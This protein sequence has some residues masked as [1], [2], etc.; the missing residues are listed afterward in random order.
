MT[1]SRELSGYRLDLVGVQEV[2]W[3][4]SGTAPAGKFTFFYGTG[5][6]SHELSTGLLYLIESY[7]KLRRLSLLMAGC[8]TY[9]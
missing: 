7:W 8:H 2:R 4:G 6:E 1:D 3:D 5:N 9:Y